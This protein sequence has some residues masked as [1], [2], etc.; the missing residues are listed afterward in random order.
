MLAIV[1]FLR[2]E[3]LFSFWVDSDGSDWLTSGL[4]G[5]K[6]FSRVTLLDFPNAVSPNVFN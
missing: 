4:M 2:S 1:L 3:E 6:L 5:I